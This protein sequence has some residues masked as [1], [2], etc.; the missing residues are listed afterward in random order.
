MHDHRQSDGLNIENLRLV[1]PGF[2]A[3]YTL[4]VERG[5]LV[6]VIGPSGCGKT[7]L[8]HAI[9]GFEE[10]V[11]GTLAWGRQSLLG[12]KPASRPVA[13]LFQEHNLF[14][15]L[16][17]A[18][19]I[20]LALR[21]DLRLSDGEWGRVEAALANVELGGMGARLPA[22]MSGGQ[23]QRVALARAM[24]SS[25]PVLLLD[26]PFAALDPG[27]RRGMIAH[28]DDLRRRF[29][30]T[31]LMT[32]HTPEDALGHADFAAFIMDGEVA[33][34]GKARDVVRRGRSQAMDQ[35]LG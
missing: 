24:V 10:P 14:A 9:A 29:Q 35:F 27:L 17:A 30:L 32:L 18:Q 19:N 33:D 12:F 6:A 5:S 1:Y 13:M 25:K 28:V 23:R 20:G 22:D 4:Q 34:F 3:S 16:S 11:S 21:T 7:T 8:L 31:V 15:H 2:V 26:E